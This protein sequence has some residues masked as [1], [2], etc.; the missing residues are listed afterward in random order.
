MTATAALLE[1]PRRAVGCQAV[2]LA[3][4]VLV[5]V[6]VLERRPVVLLRHSSPSFSNDSRRPAL[7]TEG[8]A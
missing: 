7:L 8:R 1:G 2:P 4:L 6:L 3:V 5:L